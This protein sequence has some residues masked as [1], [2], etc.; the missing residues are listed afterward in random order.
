MGFFQKLKDKWEEWYYRDLD[1]EEDSDAEEDY[2]EEE[3]EEDGDWEEELPSDVD[4]FFDD[5]DN[6]TVYV[7]EALGQMAEASERAGQYQEEY[8]AVTGLLMDMDE[9]E[10]LPFAERNSITEQAARIRRLEKERRKVYLNTGKLREKRLDLITRYEEDIPGAIQ[11]IRE[12][13]NYRK[14]IKRDLRKIEGERSSYRYQIHEAKTTIAN[15]RGVAGICGAAVMVSILLLAILQYS[16]E[17]D[18]TWGYMVICGVGA[19][20]MTV[21]FVRYLDASRSLI[22]VEKLRNKLIGLHNTVKIRYV[23][24][25]NLLQYLY[26]K[27][28]VESADELE[29]DWNTYVDEMNAKQKEDEIREDLEYYYKRLMDTLAAYQIKDPEIWTK[30]IDAL[31]EDKKMAEVRRGLIA[32]RQKLRERLEY[33][34]NVTMAGQKKIDQLKE[35]YPEYAL[36]VDSIVD[37]YE[38]S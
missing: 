33:N 22:I 16:Y 15:S 9:I 38:V 2:D 24:N 6:R 8:D 27:Y 30:Q 4:T 12:A 35:A 1:T 3:Y 7:L 31:V 13:E 21:L 19:V 25:T 29:K 14:L 23:N 17:M 28:D 11:K 5:P 26:M 10:E 36:E 32:R 37:R 18:V 34:R 20:T